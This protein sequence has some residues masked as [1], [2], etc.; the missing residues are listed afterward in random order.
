MRRPCVDF[1]L[2]CILMPAICYGQW[3]SNLSANTG[4]CNLAADQQFADCASDG[5]GG[6][7]IVWQD[8]RNGNSDIYAQRLSSAGFSLW[9][10]NGVPIST[11]PNGKG[12]PK[13]LLVGN[14]DAQIVW[15]EEVLPGDY[16]IYSQRIDKLGITQWAVN[17]VPVCTETGSQNSPQFV[18]DGDGGAIIV[19]EDYRTGIGD[20]HAQRLN[21]DGSLAWGPGKSICIATNQQSSPMIVSNDDNGATIVWEDLRNGNWDVFAQR[22]DS[23]GNALWANDGMAICT[24]STNQNNVR[25][26]ADGIGGAIYVWQDF[27]VSGNEILAQR[28]NK[29]GVILWPADGQFICNAANTQQLPA[30]ATDYEGGAVIAWQDERFDIPNPDIFAQ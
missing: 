8:F 14:G 12:Q 27:R 23:S 6:V 16:D 17:G 29:N 9:A 11:S 1:L 26:V 20:I 22:I 13:I 5:V 7:Y 24:F 15:Q 30:I 4:V 3:T 10:Q 28:T 25:L 2:F 18:R 21:S 19:W